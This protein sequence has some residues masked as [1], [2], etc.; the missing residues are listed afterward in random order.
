MFT[1]MTPLRLTTML[2]LVSYQLPVFIVYLLTMRWLAPNS[3]LPLLMTAANL[4]VAIRT[5]PTAIA[6]LIWPFGVPFA[7]R[8]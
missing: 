2:D 8:S 6:S 1:G 4:F 5:V 3:Y 7:L